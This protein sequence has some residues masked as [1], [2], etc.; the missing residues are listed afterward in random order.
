MRFATD[1]GQDIKVAKKI[2]QQIIAAITMEVFAVQYITKAVFIKPILLKD[3]TFSIH[4]LH[5]FK[6]KS[7]SVFY[8]Q[9]QLWPSG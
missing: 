1:C 5:I 2:L 4:P 7:F 3:L 8:Q 6:E 9:K